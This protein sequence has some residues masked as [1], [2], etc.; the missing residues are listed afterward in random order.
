[1]VMLYS[2]A[3]DIIINVTQCFDVEAPRGIIILRLINPDGYG[4][5]TTPPAG[6]Q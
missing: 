4:V 3:M 6:I 1:M 5:K 2:S